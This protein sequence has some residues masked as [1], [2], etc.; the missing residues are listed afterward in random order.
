MRQEP[1]RLSQSGRNNKPVERVVMMPGRRA[2]PA[3]VRETT[4]GKLAAFTG[5]L[6]PEGWLAKVLLNRDEREALRRGRRY[7]SDIAI[8]EGRHQLAALPAHMLT[9]SL[10]EYIDAGRFTG[11]YAGPARGGVGGSALLIFVT[12]RSDRKPNSDR[13]RGCCVVTQCR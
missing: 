11:F 2:G 10:A 3:L 7:M 1:K 6:L 9:A 13:L 12:T 5:S 4:P 8:V